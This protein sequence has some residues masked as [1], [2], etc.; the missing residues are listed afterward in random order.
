[1]LLPYLAAC[2][3]FCTIAVSH[4]NHHQNHRRSFGQKLPHSFYQSVSQNNNAFS[5]IHTFSTDPQPLT[6]EK[7]VDLA[8][9]FSAEK[10]NLG[11]EQFLVTSSHKSDHNGVTHVY[12]QQIINGLKVANSFANVNL[13]RSGNVLS[14]G[15]SFY[16]G[17]GI[18]PSFEKDM[19][20]NP[21]DTLVDQTD[22]AQDYSFFSFFSR[23][24]KEGE[25]KRL[26]PSDAILYLAKHLQIE[27]DQDVVEVE[28]VYNILSTNGLVT[29]SHSLKVPFA[30]SDVPCTLSYI[31][32][33][34]NG[35]TELKLV[36]DLEVE[37][38]DSWYHAHVDSDTGDVH[39]LVDWVSDATYNV[40]PL[41]V[42]DPI[43]GDRKVAKNPEN[44]AASP[45]GWHTQRGKNFSDTR[46]NNVFAQEN[47]EGGGN[48]KDNYRPNG[49]K[50][51]VFDFPYDKNKDPSTYVDLAVT[52]LFY[53]N[54]IIHDLFYVYGFDEKAGN[55]QEHNFGKGG[56]END[57]VIANAQDGSGTN[58]ANFATPP[59][60]QRG[61]MRM[62]VWDVVKPSR[63][64]DLEGGIIVHEYA[65]GISTRLTGGPANSGCLGWGE[66]GGM[67]E[68]WGDFFATIFR[69]TPKTKR[70]DV[71]AMGKYANGG[72]GIRKY[73]YSES[74]DI[75]PSTYQYIT[76]PAYWGVHAKGEVWAAIL[77]EAYWEV[78]EAV[79]FE[80]DWFNAF[81]NKKNRGK[82]TYYDI[83]NMEHVEK[84]KPSSEKLKGNTLMMQLVVDGLKLQPC[85]PS[86]VD[87]RDAIIEADEVG[88]GGEHVCLLWKGFAKRG[89]GY[90]ARAGGRQSFEIP[91]KCRSADL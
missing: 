24:T 59:D 7:A 75:N 21:D 86:F 23:T 5:F 29:P 39:S 17:S 57:G 51:L 42:N 43:D 84:K 14:F 1:M 80:A 49:K 91:G 25:K 3:V 66:S 54:N 78:V 16:L 36:W 70:S 69:H 76:K 13:D 10:L 2:S 85:Y 31:Q 22:D 11:R 73:S 19:P 58:N 8:L 64:G 46:G 15:S 55:F 30:L 4:T 89:L 20:K 44:E 38:E 47:L 72:K 82:K 63:D 32:V 12:L 53:W 61:R 37:M 56:K 45:T 62:Y 52:N 60:G 28:P 34:L 90:G 88:F 40:F 81:G 65:H 9:T 68:G 67:G 50:D 87:A 18:P 27:Y 74:M 33:H 35:N 6:V 77:L 48:W 83:F 79:G 26:N 41:G 71:F